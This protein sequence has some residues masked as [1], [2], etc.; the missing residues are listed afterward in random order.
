MNFEEFKN[1]YQHKSVKEF[2]NQVPENPVLRVLVLTYQQADYIRDCLEGI[3]MQKTNFLFEIIIGDDDSSDGTREICQEYAE[4]HPD[5]IR[6]MLHSKENN[7]SLN[8]KPTPI[9]NVFYNT[10]SARGKYIAICEGDDYWT[11][12]LKLQKQVTFM[13]TNPECSLTFH[14]TLCI[15]EKDLEI[16]HLKQP[17]NP[18][19][20]QIFNLK[21]YIA[22]KGLGIW[23]VSMMFKAVHEDQIPNWLFKAP[24]TDLALKLFSA[25]HGKIGYIPD[26]SAVYRRRTAGSW[27]EYSQTYQWQIDHLK[28]RNSTY[29]FFNAYSNYKYNSEIKATNKWWKELCLPQA[30][31]FANRS[32]RRK[33]I[34]NN[35]DYFL[36]PRHKGNFSRW[37][38][39][40][41]GDEFV[42]EIKD[43]L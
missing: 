33:L 40:I 41:F 15:D 8:Q 13:E 4:K 20:T 11:D 32:Q 19:K 30:F 38:R 37:M 27:S 18:Q 31:K 6:L 17:P 22:G 10:F 28:G 7:I 39:F 21:D 2:P 9:F 23:T 42:S 29:N 16:Q 43:N 25:Y 35:L 34:F 14:P 24:I 26:I 3:L 36:N 5:K 12:S 1:K